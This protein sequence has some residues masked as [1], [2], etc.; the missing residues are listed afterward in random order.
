[1][2]AQLENEI[3]RVS[4]DPEDNWSRMMAT[5][6]RTAPAIPLPTADPTAAEGLPGRPPGLPRGPKRSPP[7]DLAQRARGLPLLL[8]KSSNLSELSRLREPFPGPFAIGFQGRLGKLIAPS[9]RSTR[10][11]RHPVTLW[12]ATWT[13]RQNLNE[14]WRHGRRRWAL[15]FRRGAMMRQPATRSN[16]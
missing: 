12:L 3:L 4:I 15:F 11:A 8:P 13:K 6:L 10:W 16:R 2:R 9:G 7:W 14:N 5:A 1:M